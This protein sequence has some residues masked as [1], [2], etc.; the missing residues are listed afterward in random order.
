MTYED[1]HAALA[2]VEW[3]NNKDFHGSVIGVFMAE[4]KSS[5]SV[6]DSI[7]AA[8]FGVVEE[9]ASGINGGS[10]KGRGGGETTGKAWKQDGDWLCPNTRC[11]M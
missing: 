4:S 3:F 5:T 8:D 2:A 1:P 9:N 11:V 6:V 10:A 7:V